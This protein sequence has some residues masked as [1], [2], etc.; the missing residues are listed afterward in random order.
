MA[1]LRTRLRKLAQRATGKATKRQDRTTGAEAQTA[2]VKA[3]RLLLD[4]WD[5]LLGPAQEPPP[6]RKDPLRQLRGALAESG[7]TPL[8]RYVVGEIVAAV[9]RA[10]GS[11]AE[12]VAALAVAAGEDAAT[13][14][15]FARVAER[16][17][18]GRMREL[19]AAGLSWSHLVLLASIDD[20]KKREQWISRT[21]RGGL[22]VRQLEARLTRRSSVA[23]TRR[24]QG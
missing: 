4:H 19:L 1:D 23:R 18:R 12:G 2:A 15:R 24:R 16:W 21:Q 8:N 20:G 9:K 7:K 6:A 3:C 17:S 14:Y 11:G 5:E 13:L 10:G 22:T